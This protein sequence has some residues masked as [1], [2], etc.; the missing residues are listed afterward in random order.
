MGSEDAPSG[1]LRATVASPPAVLNIWLYQKAAVRQVTCPEL[2]D[3]VKEAVYP[4]A[5]DNGSRKSGTDMMPSSSG[6][7]GVSKDVRTGSRQDAEESGVLSPDSLSMKYDSLS[8]RG[9]Q[10]PVFTQHLLAPLKCTSLSC[11]F[12]WKGLLYA[13]EIN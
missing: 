2:T 13:V 7:L 11:G 3:G 9:F 6:S 8:R 12:A 10:H 4:A 5:P 1:V